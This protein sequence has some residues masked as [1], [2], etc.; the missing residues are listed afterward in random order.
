[1]NQN[2]NTLIT[3]LDSSPALRDST[4]GET[5]SLGRYAAWKRD[6]RK[7]WRCVGCGDDLEALISEH[8]IDAVTVPATMLLG[9]AR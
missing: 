1:M 5:L 2:Y 8:G 7:G 9:G 4:T 6:A 3:V